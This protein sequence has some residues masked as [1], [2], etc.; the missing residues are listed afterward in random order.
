MRPY[1]FDRSAEDRAT[2]ARWRRRVLT[3]YGGI[4]AALIAIV[5]AAHIAHVGPLFASR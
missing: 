2:I 5:A 4:G 3:F 1:D